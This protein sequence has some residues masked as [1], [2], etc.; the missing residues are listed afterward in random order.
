MGKKVRVAAIRDITDRKKA[1]KSLQEV[2]SKFR[3]IVEASPMGMHMY[4]LDDKD[5]LIFI[6]GNPAADKILDMDHKLILNKTI[7]DAFPA[8]SHTD[9][10]ERYR[11]VALTGVPWNAEQLV[12]KDEEITGVFEI[13]AFQTSPR[14]MVA[15]F[16]DITKRKEDASE[17]GTVMLSE[18]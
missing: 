7:E 13:H 2:E 14:V 8:I 12:Y 9:V 1:Q 5:R 16:F 10:S 17:N 3:S 15:G 11:A 18:P 6:D 4:R